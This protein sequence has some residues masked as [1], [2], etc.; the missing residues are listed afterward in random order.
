MS[1]WPNREK[2]IGH[3]ITYYNAN[4]KNRS[5]NISLAAK[6]LNNQVVFP[7]ETFSFNQVIG[8]RTAAKGYLRATVIVRGQELS[9]KG[10]GGGICR[11]FPLRYLI[12]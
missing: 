2:P 12:P 5:I 8:K 1:C 11:D 4:N 10:I 7:G 9:E 6:T 3:Y